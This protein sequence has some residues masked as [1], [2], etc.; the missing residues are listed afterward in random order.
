MFFSCLHVFPFATNYKN[1]FSFLAFLF[2]IEKLVKSF[3][4]LRTFM[5]GCGGTCVPVNG[6]VKWR[7]FR[8]QLKKCS[9][10]MPAVNIVLLS[11]LQI[12]FYCNFSWYIFLFF[13]FY[14]ENNVLL[15]PSGPLA[16]ALH[17]KMQ[18]SNYWGLLQLLAISC[19]TNCLDFGKLPKGSQ[20]CWL[21]NCARKKS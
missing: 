20:L 19:A 7:T 18:T 3:F 5:D 2:V 9:H 12:Y 21:W 1:T 16:Y 11:A 15:T 17:M 4:R 14:F 6:K 10:H 8:Q 13:W